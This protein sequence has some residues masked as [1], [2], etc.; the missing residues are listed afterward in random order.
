MMADFEGTPTTRRFA[1]SL[2]EAF[3][4]VRFAA[5]ERPAPSFSRV[6]SMGHRLVVAI[7]LVGL[8]ALIVI[9]FTGG[10]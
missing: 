4:D 6:N 10:Q 5:I 2:A 7:C 3:P 1:R 8:A 9:F